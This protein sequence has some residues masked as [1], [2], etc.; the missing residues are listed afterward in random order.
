MVWVVLGV[1]TRPEKQDNGNNGEKL[2]GGRELGAAV[3][4]S[5]RCEETRPALV[6]CLK[7]RHFLHMQNHKHYEIMYETGEG[8]GH[9]DCEEWQTETDTA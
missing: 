5:P 8:P 3:D 7:R 1:E 4:L 2:V 9:A 6:T